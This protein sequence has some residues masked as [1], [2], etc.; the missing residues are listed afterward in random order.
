M[1]IKFIFFALATLF[2]DV[3]GFIEFMDCGYTVETVGVKLGSCISTPCEISTDKIQE[4]EITV[5]GTQI[6]PTSTIVA[7]AEFIQMGIHWSVPITP[8][9]VCTSWSCPLEARP[10]YTFLGEIEFSGIHLK[11]PGMLQIEAFTDDPDIDPLFCI[12]I[13]VLIVN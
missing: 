8:E 11:R 6:P 1:N 3:R 13:P 7:S 9:D 4:I 10:E 12:K 5:D 2:V